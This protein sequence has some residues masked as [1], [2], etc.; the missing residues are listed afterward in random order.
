MILIWL[1]DIDLVFYII[2]MA[3]YMLLWS[4]HLDHQS[5]TLWSHWEIKLTME[6]LVHSQL[7]VNWMWIQPLNLLHSRQWIVSMSSWLIN[8]NIFVMVTG[9]FGYKSF[10]LQVE[11]PTSR[12]FHLHGLS[13]F[14][15][16]KHLLLNTKYL[17]K[18]WQI[19]LL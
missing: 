7:T 11:S 12:S 19:S 13:R 5:V 17:S 15:F 8:V 3:V 18:T 6:N 14:T 9:R 4:L 2:E 10:C 16:T 1:I